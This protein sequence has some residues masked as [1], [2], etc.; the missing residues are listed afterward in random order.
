MKLDEAGQYTLRHMLETG[1]VLL[2]LLGPPVPTAR[3]QQLAAARPRLS[4]AGLRVLAVGL[5][6][7]AAELSEGARASL[8]VVDVS[9]EVTFSLALFRATQDGGETELMLDRGGN[10]RARWTINTPEGLAPPGSL[11]TT[12]ERVARISVDAPG[13]ASHLH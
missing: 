12:A 7:S 13:H 3:L 6:A 10:V 5:D 9:S 1:P 4:D 11:V 2:L 8:F